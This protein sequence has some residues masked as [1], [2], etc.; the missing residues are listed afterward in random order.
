MSISDQHGKTILITGSNAGIGFATASILAEHGGEIIMACRNPAKAEAAAQRLRDAVPGVSLELLPLDLADLSSVRSAAD[1]LLAAQRPID[2]L[3]NNA[4]LMMP[5]FSETRDGFELQ[6]GTNVLGHFAFTG[7]ILPLLQ[8]REGARIVWLSSV[9][10]WPGRINFNNLNAEKRYSKFGAYAQSKL[11]DLMLAYEM[12]RRLARV[13]AKAISLAAHPGGTKSELS[14]NNGMLKAINVAFSRVIQETR[15]GAM[16][17]VLAATDPDA[18]GGDYYGP[19]KMLTFS[20]PA[21][22]QGSSRYSRREDI[23]GQLWQVCQKL[24][25]VSVLD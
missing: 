3:I 13:G 1:T 18:R 23:A 9:A 4:G 6:F 2:V 11:A 22:K 24:T 7:L 12:Q 16:P 17:S 15:D 10:H 20:G 5:P 19:S 21:Q 25:G 14:R 8:D